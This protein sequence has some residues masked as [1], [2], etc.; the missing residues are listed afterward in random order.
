MEGTPLEFVE[1]VRSFSAHK[2]NKDSYD[3]PVQIALE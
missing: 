1:E 2:R 3:D